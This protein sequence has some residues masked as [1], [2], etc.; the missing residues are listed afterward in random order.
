M[1]ELL[2]LVREEFAHIRSEA[3]EYKIQADTST[4]KLA[5]EVTNLAHEV[6]KLTVNVDHITNI[7]EDQK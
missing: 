4:G 6:T 5:D 1:E 7:L 3:L 2:R